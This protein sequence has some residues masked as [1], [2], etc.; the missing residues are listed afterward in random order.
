[1]TRLTENNDRVGQ[2]PVSDIQVIRCSHTQPD[3]TATHMEM[4]WRGWGSRRVPPSPPVF[5]R[6]VLEQDGRASAAQEV[7]LHLSDTVPG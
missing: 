5:C 3:A 1:M 6:S 7:L 4:G 2:Q